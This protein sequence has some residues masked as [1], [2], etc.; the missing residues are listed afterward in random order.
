MSKVALKIG[1]FNIYWYSLFILLGITVAYLI[2]NKELDKQKI[3]KDEFN[4]MAFLCIIIGIIGAR[5]YYVLFNLNYYL[6]VPTEIIA[7]WNGGLAIHGGLIASA[8][9][10]LYYT[11]KKK[12]NTLKTFDI[13]VVG[14]IIAQAIGRWGNFFNSEAYGTIT[15]LKHLKDMHL[16]NFII[17]GMYI[18]GIYYTP[19]FLYESCWN[20]LGFII[21]L[22]MR[23]NKNLKVGEL[24]G[25][26]LIW[27][28]IGRF[29][30]ESIRLDSLMLGNIK[31][32]QLVSTIIIII[33][34]I[35]LFYKVKE[36]EKYNKY[37]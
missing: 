13:I 1:I 33:G 14:L 29:F 35:L 21:L 32:A 37:L 19:T 27:Y 15:S 2:I 36:R 17:K 11:N 20:I 26:Y 23:R 6:T 34:L 22:F 30:I 18:K 10:I 31:I 7:M 5:I 9:Y 12:L 8:L 3:N 28:G 4:D 24:T 16:P 25:I